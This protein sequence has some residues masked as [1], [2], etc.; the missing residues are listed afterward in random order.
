M[1]N[2]YDPASCRVDEAAVLLWEWERVFGRVPTYMVPVRVCPTEGC[3][4]PTHLRL[5][6]DPDHPWPSR[7]PL[8]IYERTGR[9]AKGRKSR[10]LTGSDVLKI[11]KDFTDR[12]RVW[13]VRGWMVSKAVD[14]KV[15]HATIR[16][17]VYRM[18]T[19]Y[20]GVSHERNREDKR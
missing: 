6:R 15:G 10:K 20:G 4:C 11:R 7:I 14:Y 12:E 19:C 17:V 9:D 13:T 16:R 2:T 1:S 18:G 3:V 5:V 8:P